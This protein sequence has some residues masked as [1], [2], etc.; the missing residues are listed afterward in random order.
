MPSQ[1][2][3]EATAQPLTRRRRLSLIFT[4]IGLYGLYF[5]IN[6]FLQGAERSTLTTSFDL[7]VPLSPSWMLIYGG[8]YFI[9]LAPLLLIQERESFQRLI[10]AGVI[11][12]L[13]SL[14]LFVLFP[15]QMELRPLNASGEDLS[16][17]AWL[18]QLCYFLDPPN[19]CFPSLHVSVS[20]LAALSVATFDRRI[21]SFLIIIAMLISASTLFVKQHYVADVIAGAVLA[22]G[23]WTFILQ[24]YPLSV[25]QR[26]AAIPTGRPGYPVLVAYGLAVAGSFCLWS[27][28]W[29]PWLVRA[30]D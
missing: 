21:G 16:F 12:E 1:L 23:A 8:I 2:S 26:S 4:L 7:Q 20:W 27:L 24:R 22:A 15:V 29:L 10:W 14:S 9:G 6:Q 28:D 17:T 5:P 11:V 3:S 25:E 30:V 18:L 13:V 19:C